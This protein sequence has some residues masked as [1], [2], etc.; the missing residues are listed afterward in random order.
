MPRATAQKALQAPA[1]VAV[2]PRVD[3]TH[4]DTQTTA[5][6]TSLSIVQMEPIQVIAA[7]AGHVKR[8]T[9]AAKTVLTT[10]AAGGAVL[11]RRH[12]A[13]L[14]QDVHGQMGRIS[15][16]RVQADP[17][18]MLPHAAVVSAMKTNQ[19]RISL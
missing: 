17:P 14:F 13:R 16:A 7:G 18:P 3:Q 9:V 12:A 6:V 11:M 15:G 1:E 2:A 19:Q 4:A 10:C 5:S 8:L